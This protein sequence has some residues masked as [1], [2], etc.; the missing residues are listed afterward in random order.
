MALG[1]KDQALVL[2]RKISTDVK[3]IEGAESKYHVA[4]ILYG[5]GQVDKAQSEIFD[6]IDKTT[7]Y[8]FWMAKSFILLAEIYK[9]KKDN[10]QALQTLKSIIDYY[11]VKDDGILDEAKAKKAEIELLKHPKPTN[12]GSMNQSNKNNQS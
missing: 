4:E 9:K 6:F 3:T 11:E 8:Q 7:P 12:V 10:Y 2:Y 5:Q 1:N